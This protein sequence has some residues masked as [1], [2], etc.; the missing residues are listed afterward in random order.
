MSTDVYVPEHG[1]D[2]HMSWCPRDHETGQCELEVYV[3]N[4]PR[5]ATAA[6]TLTGLHCSHQRMEVRG[7][8]ST[9]AGHDHLLEMIG[10]LRELSAGALVDV[11]CDQ[12]PH[13]HP[14]D[15]E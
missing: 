8:V 10:S 2:L 9:D 15:E 13:L 3:Y 7:Y 6:V 4:E 11:D 5:D 14:D 12:H 1:W